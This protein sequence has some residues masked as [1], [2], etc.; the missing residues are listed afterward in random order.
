M[1]LKDLLIRLI[2]RT[3]QLAVA[4]VFVMSLYKICIQIE[5]NIVPQNLSEVMVYAIFIGSLVLFDYI[6]GDKT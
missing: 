2:N 4:C 1:V 6:S 5:T 3:A